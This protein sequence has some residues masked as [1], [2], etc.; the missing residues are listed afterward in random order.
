MTPLRTLF[1][2]AALCA[3]VLLALAALF[4][5]VIGSGFMADN[6]LVYQGF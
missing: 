5:T 6:A 3:A 4:L 2:K 1:E